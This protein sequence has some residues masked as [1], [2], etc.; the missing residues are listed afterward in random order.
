MGTGIQHHQDYQRFCP[1]EERIKI[2]D[3]ICLGRRRSNFPKCKGC[4]F[5]D[6]EKK[7]RGALVMP[8][9]DRTAAE[10]EKLKRERIASVFKA[11]EVRGAYPEPLDEELAW[12]VGQATATFLRSELRGYERSRSEKSA[13]VVGRDMRKSSASLTAALIEGLRAGGSSVIDIG[14]V[15]TPQLYFAVNHVTCCGGVQVTGGHDPAACNG[16]KICGEK[17]KPVSVD[18]G[19]GKICKAA[20]NTIRHTSPQMAGQE[21]RDLSG[22][23]KI[24]VRS[25]LTSSPSGYSPERPMKVVVDAS[26]GMGGRWF[27]ILFG[28][29]EWLEVTRLNFEHNGTFAHEPNPM[30]E[31]NLGQLRDRMRRTRAAFGV[32]FDGDADSVVFVDHEGRIVPPDLLTAL[33]AGAFLRKAP[34]ASIAYDMQSSRVVPEEIRKAGG[35]PRRERSGHA[36]LQKAM[37]DAKAVFGGELSGHYYFRDNG[38]CDSGVMAFAHVVNLLLETGQTLQELIAPLRRY[39]HSGERTFRQ[40]NK[41]G[42]LQQLAVRYRDAEVDLLDG[43]TVQYADWWFNVRPVAGEPLLKFVA[44]ARDEAMLAARLTELTPLLGEPA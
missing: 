26:N 12:R 6:D 24:F 34:G 16:F 17:G 27:P 5:N 32:C 15:D 8:G 35:V 23:Y 1:G 44:E 3:A 7:A 9:S 42:A 33:L 37:I 30:V 29:V 21:Q 11:S 13:V 20:V 31:P 4:Q 39:T 19:L 28:D 14:M 25:F 36:Y 2:S 38:W 40:E 43:L 18:T 22:P 41:E 10:A